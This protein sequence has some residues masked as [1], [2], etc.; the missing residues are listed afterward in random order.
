MPLNTEIRRASATAARVEPV[1]WLLALSEIRD[2]KG[3]V[4]PSASRAV[5]SKSDTAASSAQ[6]GKGDTGPEEQL[7]QAVTKRSC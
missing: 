5:D 2:D 6:D 3:D 4:E 1:I 7:D